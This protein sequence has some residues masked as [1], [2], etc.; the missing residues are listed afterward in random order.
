MYIEFYFFFFTF[1][2]FLF[3]TFYY[4]ALVYGA[5]KYDLSKEKSLKEPSSPATASVYVVDVPALTGLHAS[6]RTAL[7]KLNLRNGC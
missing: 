5:R 4:L 3:L 7:G 6:W 1:F 2:L